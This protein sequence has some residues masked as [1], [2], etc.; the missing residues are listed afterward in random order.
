MRYIATVYLKW[1]KNEKHLETLFLEL[2]E[3]NIFK[4]QALFQIRNYI[5]IVLR[6]T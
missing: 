1:K 3:D 6:W 4:Q 2:L 5:T